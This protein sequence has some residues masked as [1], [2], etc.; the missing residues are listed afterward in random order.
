[1]GRTESRKKSKR[2]KTKNVNDCHCR[3]WTLPR[4]R[5]LK[6]RNYK[7]SIKAHLPRF[8]RPFELVSPIKWKAKL[9][10]T[11]GLALTFPGSR[12]RLICTTAETPRG[13]ENSYVSAFRYG[14]ANSSCRCICA[15]Q[16]VIDSSEPVAETCSREILQSDSIVDR[17]APR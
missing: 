16:G 8:R 11:P 17:F 6:T 4:T 5:Q 7:S 3:F 10:F 2:A 15:H 13:L 1:L 12:G 9:D 14:D